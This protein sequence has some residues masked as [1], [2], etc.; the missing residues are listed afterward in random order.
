MNPF[1]WWLWDSEGT[2]VTRRLE[3]LGRVARQRSRPL[4]EERIPCMVVNPYTG[5]G[6]SV[7]GVLLDEI[8]LSP[9]EKDAIEALRIVDPRISDVRM[10]GPFGSSRQ[11]TAIVGASH[12][13]RP[14]PLRSFG[15]GM[16]RLFAIVLSL[17]NASG[18]ILLI[19]E[20]EN[21]LH[22]SVQLNAWRMIF[23]LASKLNTQVFATSHSNDAI[24]AFQKAA[25]ETPE[26]GALVRLT[27]RGEETI[28]TVFVER[29]LA[30]ATR[31]EIEV[32]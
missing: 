24:G 3:S 27:R 11:R 14:V 9:R 26:E 6:T 21:G 29:E 7:L 15:D 28:P 5:E 12:I 20:F 4:V 32:R 19:D 25:A 23:G 10:V 13:A 2:R 22:H 17:A 16:S 18:G 8:A 31:D 1:L 30:I